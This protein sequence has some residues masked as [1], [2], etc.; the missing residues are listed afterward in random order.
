MVLFR[1]VISAIA[2]III[3]ACLKIPM[4]L[5]VTKFAPL[6]VVA[7]MLE[8]KDKK[9]VFKSVFVVQKTHERN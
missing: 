9:S 3:R 4:T 7:V 1:L 2:H 8:E 5:G 6:L